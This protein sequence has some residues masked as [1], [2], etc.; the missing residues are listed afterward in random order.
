MDV[1]R[2]TE[3]VPAEDVVER[4]RPS[5]PKPPVESEDDR[6]ERIRCL[7]DFHRLMKMHPHDCEL[8]QPS[9]DTPLDE[10]RYLYERAVARI[11]RREELEVEATWRAVSVVTAL[12]RALVDAQPRN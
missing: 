9:V 7:C 12:L 10:L 3:H 5:S 6:R 8:W 4:A 2:T 1:A 11:R